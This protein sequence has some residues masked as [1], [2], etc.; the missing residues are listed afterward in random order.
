MY[1]DTQSNSFTLKKVNL[2]TGIEFGEEFIMR[3]LTKVHLQ[4]LPK[5]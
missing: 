1:V 3:S 4:E 2:N 5:N